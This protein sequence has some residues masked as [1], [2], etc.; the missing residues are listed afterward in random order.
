MFGERKGKVARVGRRG[1]GG[2]GGKW[3]R[4]RFR[5]GTFTGEMPVEGGEGPDW[6]GRS[7]QR[8]ETFTKNA[9]DLR[10]NSFFKKSPQGEKKQSHE[11]T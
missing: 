1:R 4:S 2:G 7:P 6:W 3:G 9:R 11:K 8:N 5:A 10:H